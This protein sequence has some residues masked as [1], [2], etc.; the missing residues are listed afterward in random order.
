MIVESGGYSP[1]ALETYSSI[2]PVWRSGIDQFD[3]RDI[4]CLVV[5]LAHYVDGDFLEPFPNLLAL[6]SPT[7]GVTHMDMQA[8]DRKGVRVFTLRDCMPKLEKITSTAEHALCLMLSLVRR[9]PQ[10]HSSTIERGE[11]NRDEFCSRQR[12]LPHSNRSR[13]S[14]EDSLD[15]CPESLSNRLWPAKYPEPSRSWGKGLRNYFSQEILGLAHRI[16]RTST[17][18]R[19]D[20]N[21]ESIAGRTHQG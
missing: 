14:Q 5:R 15:S 16:G 6:A 9:L 4:V 13:V 19:S 8:C 21:V 1:A 7:T 3:P 10:A 2:G 12:A 18:V 17:D 20:Q 11:W